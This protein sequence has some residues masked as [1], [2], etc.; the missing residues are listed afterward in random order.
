MFTLC[1]L[2]FISLICVCGWCLLVIMLPC[3]FND[4]VYTA[5]FIH[6]QMMSTPPSASVSPSMSFHEMS[7]IQMQFELD[8]IHECIG[9]LQKNKE[10][11]D[12]ELLAKVKW[13]WE[14]TGRCVRYK[15]IL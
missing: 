7:L 12:G 9:Q 15:K 1:F 3:T 14:L 10:M 8:D 2:N 13:E 4:Q 11:I 5:S 6:M